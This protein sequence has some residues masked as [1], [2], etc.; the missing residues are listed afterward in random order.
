M[1][2]TIGITFAIYEIICGLINKNVVDQSFIYVG[3]GMIVGFLIAFGVYLFLMI[4]VRR[5]KNSVAGYLESEKLIKERLQKQNSWLLESKENVQSEFET[6]IQEYEEK[7]RQLEA[8][9]RYMDES[10]LLLQKDNEET[11]ALLN[12]TNPVVHNLKIK[13]LE[14]NNTIS[15]IKAQVPA[16]QTV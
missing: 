8:Q 10:I 4:R 2:K 16:K 5:E 11:T 6:R 1:G 12:A 15:R 7:I 3:S 13:L 14:A 9:V